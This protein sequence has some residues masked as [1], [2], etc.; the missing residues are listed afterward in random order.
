MITSPEEEH[1]I[2][3]SSSK[4]EKERGREG[5]KKGRRRERE[6]GGRK[7]GRGYLVPEGIEKVRQGC[8]RKCIKDVTLLIITILGIKYKATCQH[9]NLY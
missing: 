8:I 7:G 3:S 6:R 1:L 9:P 4:V 5:V 2:V